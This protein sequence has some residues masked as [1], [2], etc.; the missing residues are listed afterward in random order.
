MIVQEGLSEAVQWLKQLDSETR[1]YFEG[2]GFFSP[3]WSRA[4]RNLTKG[5]WQMIKEIILKH[6]FP[7]VLHAGGYGSFLAIHEHSGMPEIKPDALICIE[8][9]QLPF[10]ASADECYVLEQLSELTH[11]DRNT[12][13]LSWYG[14]EPLNKDVHHYAY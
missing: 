7:C 4:L 13:I 8:W 12:E 11:R 1:E 5:E 9:S 10:G 3:P 2:A 14:F 6:E